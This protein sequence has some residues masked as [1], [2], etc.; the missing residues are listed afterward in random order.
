MLGATSEA[1]T[2]LNNTYSSFCLTLFLFIYKQIYSCIFEV[3]VWCTRSE[4]GKR[5]HNKSVCVNWFFFKA[6]LHMPT[7]FCLMS[8]TLIELVSMTKLK[9]SDSGILSVLFVIKEHYIIIMFIIYYYKWNIK[10]FNGEQYSKWKFRLRLLIEEDDIL[11][12]L[13]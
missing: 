10:R 12:V 5:T 8:P 1:N 9:F 13:D 2:F 6:I 11:Q 3:S 7:G 4:S